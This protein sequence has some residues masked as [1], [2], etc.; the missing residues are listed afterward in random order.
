MSSSHTKSDGVW[1]DLKKRIRSGKGEIATNN[2]FKIFFVGYG[3]LF[4]ILTLWSSDVIV[5]N[6]ERAV[7]LSLGVLLLYVVALWLIISG[8]WVFNSTGPKS[9]SILVLHLG[10]YYA[11][12][13]FTQ[14]FLQSLSLRYLPEPTVLFIVF[15]EASILGLV[16]GRSCDPLKTTIETDPEE[17][18]EEPFRY[19]E[20]ID[21]FDPDEKVRFAELDFTLFW[22]WAQMATT[23][24]V[25]FGIGIAATSP[26]FGKNV[27]TSVADIVVHSTVSAVGIIYLSVFVLWKMRIIRSE[28]RDIYTESS[29]GDRSQ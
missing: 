6:N 22:R 13:L 8:F 16:Y 19:L 2:I 20:E 21:N 18:A 7:A 12:L 29:A 17:D 28:I 5:V 25:A 1:S 9:I 14:L 27:V 3:T 24:F 4:Q 10:T 15:I 23:F 11:Y 26:D